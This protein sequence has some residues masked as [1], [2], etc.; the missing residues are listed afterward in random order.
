MKR[1]WMLLAAALLLTGGSAVRAEEPAGVPGT[2]EVVPPTAAP[3]PACCAAPECARH[4]KCHSG[5]LHEWLCYRPP[6]THCACRCAVTPC[7]PP[8]YLWFVDMCQGGDCGRG[9]CAGGHCKAARVEAPCAS[10]GCA[11]GGCAAP[12]QPH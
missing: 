11:S 3:A 8:L 1:V 12:V 7:I 6:S 2:M 9:H 4:G 10:G 5:H